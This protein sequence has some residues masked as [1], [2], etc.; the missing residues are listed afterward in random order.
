LCQPGKGD[1]DWRAAL[2]H[3]W[4]LLDRFVQE[5]PVPLVRGGTAS[6]LPPTHGALLAGDGARYAPLPV[7]ADVLTPSGWAP[8]A[9]LC[10]SAAS[11]VAETCTPGRLQIDRVDLRLYVCV[12][13]TWQWIALR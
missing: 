11:C 8:P 1:A 3:D 5:C 13:G 9:A 6:A 4:E 10:G 7:G 12:E 2:N